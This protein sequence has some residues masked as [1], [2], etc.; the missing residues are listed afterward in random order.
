MHSKLVHHSE[1]LLYFFEIANS[2]SYRAAANKLRVSA[3]TLTYSMKALEDAIDAS[4]LERSNQ[5]VALTRSGKILL[6]FC[7]RFFRD[8]DQTQLQIRKGIENKLKFLILVD[9]ELSM[10]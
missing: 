5:G 7:R 6:D 4:L 9:T 8:I 1:K 3:S 10:V 2:G